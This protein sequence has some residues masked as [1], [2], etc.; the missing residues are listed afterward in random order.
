[1]SQLS[2]Q[3]GI[4]V[5]LAASYKAPQRLGGQKSRCRVGDAKKGRGEDRG[6]RGGERK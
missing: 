6:G 5:V 3:M 1:M 4:A 2:C